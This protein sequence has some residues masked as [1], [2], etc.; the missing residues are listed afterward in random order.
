M[1]RL[2]VV[3][4][5]EE[6][7]IILDGLDLWD[8]RQSRDQGDHSDADIP[9]AFADHVASA[10]AADLEIMVRSAREAETAAS[11][12]RR[13][14]GGQLEP[15]RRG[16]ADA[17]LWPVAANPAALESRD[18]GRDAIDFLRAVYPTVD[19]ATRARFEEAVALHQ[20]IDT[21]QW[22]RMRDRLVS[23]LPSGFIL[24]K[25]L[26]RRRAAL[27]RKDGLRA[28]AADYS[29]YSPQGRMLR[30]GRA[31]EPVSKAARAALRIEKAAEHCRKAETPDRLL[32]LWD[33]IRK[34]VQLANRGEIEADEV[35]SLWGAIANGFVTLT[36]R[37][38]LVPGTGGIPPLAD[39]LALLDRLAHSNHP[40]TD[41]DS[42]SF[43]ND[44]VRVHAAK[45]AMNLARRFL[46]GADGLAATM[47]FFSPTNMPRFGT[48][49]P[50]AWTGSRRTR[51]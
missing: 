32:K 11:V 29:F 31:D 17:L 25:A 2:H 49:L 28:N 19:A 4:G 12:W 6:I 50:N 8:W 38:G 24:S 43:S 1:P 16:A 15:D 7:A 34:A 46:V 45:A 51:R 35:P 18:L 13:L 14:F 22:T 40:A 3:D 39:L 27:A 5:N 48:R 23:T 20:P 9:V 21:E 26:K 41:E 37:P 36:G 30:P 47:E 10:S 44:A 42:L 33:A